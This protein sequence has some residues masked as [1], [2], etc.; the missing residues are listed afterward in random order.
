MLLTAG[1]TLAGVLATRALANALILRGLRAP[2]LAH[3]VAPVDVG[4]AATEVRLPGADGKTLFAWFVPVPGVAQAPAVLVM[5]GWGANASMMLP[6]VAPLQLA[7]F[8]VLLLDARCHGLSAD[9]AFT[10]LPRFSEDIELGLDWLATQPLVDAHRLTL[11]GHSVGAAA[12][13]LCA[14]RRKDVRA[15]VS[16]S[17]FAHPREVMQR[18]LA[19]KRIPYV[20]VGWYVLRR[21][22]QV[23]GSSFDDIAPVR[24][25][26]KIGCP[27]LLVHGQEDDLVP[28]EDALRLRALGS[29]AVVELLPVAGRH[30]PS[31]ALQAHAL[32]LTLFLQRSLV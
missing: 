24:S 6:L 29:G 27:V 16:V 9:A 11:I 14:S 1:L 3:Q 26:A 20:P 31:D 19:E 5:H 4:L 23:I 17:A 18:L 32:D 2:R 13:L 12:A 15:V 25:M 8:A 10:S 21:V 30:D 28:F 22:Q 7:G